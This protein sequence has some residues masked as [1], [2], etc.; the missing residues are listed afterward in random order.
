MPFQPSRSAYRFDV[1]ILPPAW[2]LAADFAHFG[3]QVKSFREPLK[4][5]IQQ[6]IAPHIQAAFEVGGIPPWA[7]LAESTLEYK[8]QQGYPSTP[9]TATG[10]LKRIAG[11]LNA[12]TITTETATFENLG[13]AEYGV[14]HLTGTKFMP[15]RDWLS[16]VDQD[17]DA[18]AKVFGDWIIERFERRGL[19]VPSEFSGASVDDSFDES[20]DA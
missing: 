10:K 18:I 14:F 5:S 16:T 4:R 1:V 12:W 17:V 15:Q 13:A 2:V 20:V 11:Q 8:G 7:P 19:D 6:V 3:L 9:L